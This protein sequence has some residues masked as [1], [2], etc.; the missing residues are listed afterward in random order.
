MADAVRD[1]DVIILD[2]DFVLLKLLVKIGLFPQVVLHLVIGIANG[3]RV[4]ICPSRQ[5][6][7]KNIKRLFLLNTG[8][9]LFLESRTQVIRHG[10]GRIDQCDGTLSDTQVRRPRADG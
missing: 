4:V 3:F 10:I 7:D 5:F 8:V 6:P 2:A 1:L 9:V